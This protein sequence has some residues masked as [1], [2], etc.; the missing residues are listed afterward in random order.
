MKVKVLFVW[1]LLSVILAGGIAFS[2]TGRTVMNLNGRWEFEQTETA[3]PPEKFTRSIAVPGLIDLAEPKIEQYQK[4]FSGTHQPRYN[5]YR[6]K[7]TADEQH[8][9]KFAVLNLL[10]SRFDTQVILNGH[11]LGTYM[12]C[13]TPIECNLTPFIS[14]GDENI[15]L[16]RV[17]ERAWLPKQ[18]AT[19]VDREKYTDIPGVWDDVFV[20]FTGPVRVERSLILPDLRNSKVTAK[21]MI[22]NHENML[23]RSMYLAE[24]TGTVSAYIREKKGGRKVTDE[25]SQE[26]SLY[27]QSHTPVVLEL[28]LENAHPWSPENPFL[29]EA[30]VSVSVDCVW[31]YHKQDKNMDP[32][33]H[34]YDESQRTS[35][36]VATSFGMRDFKAVERM[37]HLNGRQYRLMGSTINLFRFFEDPERAGLPW[38]KEWVKKMFIAIPKSLRWNGF[39]M[40]IGLAPKFWYDL[41]DEHGPIYNEREL[42]HMQDVKVLTEKAFPLQVLLGILLLILVGVMIYL[43]GESR[44]AAL[45]G[46]VG[47]AALTWVILVGLTLLVALNF[48][49][50]FTHFHLILFEGDTWLFPATDTLIRLFPP[51]FWFD[52]ALLVGLLTLAQAAVVGGV[53]WFLGRRIA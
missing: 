31:R 1:L 53:A 2:D 17:G 42:R 16:I 32:V 34:R 10:K 6:C 14:Y 48:D 22:E 51:Q 26:F 39:R 9:G 49:W 20:T 37:F 4:Y 11:D 5:W 44:R 12:Q 30:V 41:A 38:D 29:Y 40:C 21:I 27:C 45:Q 46:L 13:N 8:R 35:D 19:G 28:P 24:T 3:F 50:F 15:L 25:V 43:G 36:V 7:F 52:A 33:I 23:D 18:S 47:G